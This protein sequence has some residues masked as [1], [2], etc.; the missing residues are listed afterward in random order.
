MTCAQCGGDADK[1]EKKLLNQD[2]DFA[3]GEACEKEYKRERDHFF[4][5]LVHDPDK[6]E[7]WLRGK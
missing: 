1:L 6:M 3:C 2:G 5:T 4:N 7:K